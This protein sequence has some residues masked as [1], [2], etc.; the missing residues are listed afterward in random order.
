MGDKLHIFGTC[1]GTES[2]RML[3]DGETLNVEEL[4]CGKGE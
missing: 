2:M 1:S 3:N 4:L